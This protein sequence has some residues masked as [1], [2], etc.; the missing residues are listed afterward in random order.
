MYDR[1]NH[2]DAK[3]R[4]NPSIGQILALCAWIGRGSSLIHSPI[5]DQRSKKTSKTN[6]EQRWGSGPKQVWP[7]TQYNLFAFFK[8]KPHRGG[9]YLFILFRPS[10]QLPRTLE[11]LFK[12]TQHP[13][14]AFNLTLCIASANKYPVGCGTLRVEIPGNGL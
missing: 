13:S 6:L 7:L 8:K 5:Q 2:Q 11:G 9:Y 4:H 10:H 1:I 12:L 14:G 3:R